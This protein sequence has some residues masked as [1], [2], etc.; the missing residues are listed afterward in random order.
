MLE[1]FSDGCCARQPQCTE[2]RQCVCGQPWAFRGPLQGQMQRLQCSAG[3]V[4]PA[5]GAAAGLGRW[6]VGGW[7]SLFV[8]ISRGRGSTRQ[9]Q[10]TESCQCVI[11]N[12]WPWASARTNVAS[13]EC[14]RCGGAC[15]GCCGRAGQVVCEECDVIGLRRLHWGSMEGILPDLLTGESGILRKRFCP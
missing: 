14:S 3:L 11:G 1:L 12:P 7:F 8:E 5:L 15:T 6:L 2:P 9:P 13:A 4:E 10:H